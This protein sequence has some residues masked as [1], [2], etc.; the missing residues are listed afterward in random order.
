VVPEICRHPWSV[1]WGSETRLCGVVHWLRAKRTTRRRTNTATSA[2]IGTT[3]YWGNAI[4][5]SR[6]RGGRKRYSRFTAPGGG[7]ST[8]FCW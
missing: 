3:S 4:H 6:R 5:E 1:G 7:Q 2:C 8:E